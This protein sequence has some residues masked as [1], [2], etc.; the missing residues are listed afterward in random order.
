MK[1]IHN[2]SGLHE[3]LIQIIAK[4]FT[5]SPLQDNGNFVADNKPY[6][7]A[8]HLFEITIYKKDLFVYKLLDILIYIII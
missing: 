3:P 4:Q 6:E 2:I 5:L 8:K 1:D 7:A